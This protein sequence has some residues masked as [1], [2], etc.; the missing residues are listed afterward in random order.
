[1]F[2]LTRC[3]A[4][5]SSVRAKQLNLTLRVTSA[6]ASLFRALPAFSW[7]RW[8]LLLV[9]LLLGTDVVVGVLLL[10]Q[11]ACTLHSPALILVE[12]V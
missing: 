9:L 10:P 4:L 1:M 5:H 12:L 8:K 7:R 2:L 6:E 11:V 3:S